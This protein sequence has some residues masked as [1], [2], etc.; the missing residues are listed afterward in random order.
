MMLRRV[1][2]GGQPHTSVLQVGQQTMRTAAL[3]V[4]SAWAQQPAENVRKGLGDRVLRPFTLPAL[5]G[6]L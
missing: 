2:A 5:R 6:G 4:P 3:V 1:R